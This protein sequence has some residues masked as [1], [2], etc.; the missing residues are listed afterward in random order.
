MDGFRLISKP[1]LRRFVCIPLLINTILFA[2]LFLVMQ[3]YMGAF[4]HWF[5]HYLPA[6]LH[7]LSVI[8]WIVF[9]VSFFLIL[10]YTF[11]TIAN[12]ICAPFN[13]FLAEKVELYLTGQVKE[14]R[15][16]YENFKDIPRIVGRQLKILGYYLPRALLILILL[17]L[18]V[19]QAAAAIV[20]FLFNA[21]FMAL[22]YI[23]YPTDNNRVSISSVRVWLN[24]RRWVAL[25]FGGSVLVASMIP[26]VNF[27]T[28]PAAVAA[29]TKWWV[30][31]QKSNS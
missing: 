30:E 1:G 29:A 9:F 11:V 22:T 5:E 2:L 31:E 21:W 10:T 7:W 13:S 16:L 24:E 15:S 19:V 14:S 6:W 4:N 3:H 27:F 8:L 23:D 12:I 17:F 20:W 28:I 18:P 25:G 26:I